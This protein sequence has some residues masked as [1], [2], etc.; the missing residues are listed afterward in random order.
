MRIMKS[1]TQSLVHC[2]NLNQFV[3]R[4]LFLVKKE[5]LR[6]HALS[7]VKMRN[8]ATMELVITK[9]RKFPSFYRLLSI[10]ILLCSNDEISF[11]FVGL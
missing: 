2:L 6:N 4:A 9:M 3:K 11:H 7:Y 5:L 1:Q 10:L 8:V